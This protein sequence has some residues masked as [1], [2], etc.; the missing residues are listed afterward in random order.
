MLRMYWPNES[1]PSIIDGTWTIPPVKKVY[2]RSCRRKGGGT[3]TLRDHLRAIYTAYFVD[4]E[5]PFGRQDPARVRKALG[6]QSNSRAADDLAK[7][8]I[9]RHRR[10]QR[11]RERGRCRHR[12]SGRAMERI[13]GLSAER[14]TIAAVALTIGMAVGASPASAQTS[15]DA[16]K[17][18]KAMTDYVAA[19][20]DISATYDAD[21]EVITAQLQKLQFTSSGALA[22]EPSRQDPGDAQRRVFRSGAGVQRRDRDRFREAH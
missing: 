5:R 2:V 17:I 20:K 21:V 18:L 9:R 19:Q 8:V 7:A 4:A 22:F 14:R 11:S 13:M 10:R 3:V 1:E 15:E 16:P 12:G 6:P